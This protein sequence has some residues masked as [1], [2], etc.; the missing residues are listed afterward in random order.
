MRDAEFDNGEGEIYENE[1]KEKEKEKR[2][3]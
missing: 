2:V 3:K 1:M